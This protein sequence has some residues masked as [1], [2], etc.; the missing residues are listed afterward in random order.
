MTGAKVKICGI[1]D[2]SAARAAAQGADYMGFIMSQRFWRYVEPDTVRDICQQ[3]PGS[4]KV[5]V[6]VDEPAEQ[7]AELAAYCNLDFV[8]LH[9]HEDKEYAEGLRQLLQE[10]SPKTRI[11]KAFRYGE[12][13]SIQAANAY[14]SDMV[15]IDSYSKNAEGGNGIT[16]AWHQAAEEIKKVQRPYL[17]AGGISIGNVRE[18]ME[19]FQP[20]GVDVSSALERDRQ[21]QDDLIKEFL[22]EAGRL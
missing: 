16:F 3:V 19:I 12:D 18:A 14:P 22:Q 11:I 17:I 1:R 8:Q 5:G 9:G 2:L 20:H 13:F 4:A 15:L 7:I 21:K 6:F 10:K